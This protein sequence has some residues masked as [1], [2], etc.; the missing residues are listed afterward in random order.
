MSYLE[1]IAD[2][3]RKEVAERMALTPIKKLEQSIYFPAEGVSLREYL[4]REDKSGVIAEFKKA[5][6][7]RGVF[8]KYANPMKVCLGYMQAGASALSVLTDQNYFAGSNE[9]LTTARE[10]NYCPILRKDF[11]VNEYQIIEAKSIGA[12]VVL[13]IADILSEEEIKSFTKLSHDLG[14]E[15]ILEIHDIT[16]LP[17]NLDQIDVVGVNARSLKELKIIPDQHERIK[18]VLPSGIITIAESGIESP[19]QAVKLKSMGYQGFLIGSHFMLDSDPV[20]KCRQFIE[21]ME[22]MDK[23][24]FA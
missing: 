23:G 7:S 6:P 15:V 1:K 9:D 19:Q 17:S 16:E 18:A 3:K 21:E 22:N 14:M 5:S 10:W 24:V 12:D 13:L 11:T 20:G 2:F 4:L 8:N